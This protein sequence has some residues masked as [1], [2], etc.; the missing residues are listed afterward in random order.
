M[1]RFHFK[2]SPG[3]HHVLSNNDNRCT[4]AAIAQFILNALF[5]RRNPCS[6]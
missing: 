4:N 1:C 2:L 6:E 5:S 3:I